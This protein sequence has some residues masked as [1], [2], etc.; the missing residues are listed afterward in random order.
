MHTPECFCLDWIAIQIAGGVGIEFYFALTT[1]LGG[2][3][4]FVVDV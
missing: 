3:A 2:T 1:V 4:P